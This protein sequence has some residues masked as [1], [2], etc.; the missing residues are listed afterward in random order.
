MREELATQLD[1]FARRLRAPRIAILVY[2]NLPTEVS[3]DLGLRPVIPI[4]PNGTLHGG[5]QF[6]AGSGCRWPVMSGGGN[7]LEGVLNILARG[8]L[9]NKNAQLGRIDFQ[10]PPILLA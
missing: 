10:P 1:V 3:C 8:K 2:G 7:H 6:T 5:E 9:I 4:M